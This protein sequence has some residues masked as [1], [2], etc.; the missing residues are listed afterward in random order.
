MQ[1][2]QARRHTN[3]NTGK[4]NKALVPVVNIAVQ[5]E[6]YTRSM[7]LKQKFGDSFTVWLCWGALQVE[8]KPH[9]SDGLNQDEAGS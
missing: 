4:Q 9:L 2:Q 7:Q 1:H 5:K 6:A 8:C 3:C